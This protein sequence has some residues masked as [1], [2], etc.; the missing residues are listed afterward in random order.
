MAW[1]PA[2]AGVTIGGTFYEFINGRMNNFHQ[3]VKK[4]G[5]KDGEQES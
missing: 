4:G 2:F 5:A 3:P 1:T